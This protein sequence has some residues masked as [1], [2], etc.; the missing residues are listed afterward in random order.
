[1]LT[2]ASFAI[3]CYRVTVLLNTRTRSIHKLCPAPG[4]MIVIPFRPRRLIPLEAKHL[5]CKKLSINKAPIVFGNSHKLK[6]LCSS[7]TRQAF[8]AFLACFA[9]TALCTRMN[10]E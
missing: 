2:F 10:P 5:A 4:T 6:I 9:P 3:S 7:R 8:L 1:M